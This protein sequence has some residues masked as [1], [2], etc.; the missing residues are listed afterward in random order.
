MESIRKLI[1]ET[2]DDCSI[3]EGANSFINIGPNAGLVTTRNTSD[4]IWLNLFDFKEKKCIGI[5]TLRKVSDRA[6]G[7]TT[8][9]AEK[10]NGSLMYEFGMMSVYPAGICTDRLG[11]TKDGAFSVFQKFID[12]RSD[13]RKVF[14]KKED[15]EYS[16]KYSTDET[17]S[18]LEN[19]ICFKPTSIW[20]KKFIDKGA[21]LMEK[22][23]ISKV[24]IEEVCRNYFVKRY[25]TG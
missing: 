6:W 17:K 12:N 16:T 4:Q 10:G 8:V 7:V 20:F 13:I 25:K 2:L 1:R 14:I 11:L 21:A 9:A 24:E 18:I 5:I 22:T 3:F 23:G 15:S 19:I